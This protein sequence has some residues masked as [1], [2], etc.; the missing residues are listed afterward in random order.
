MAPYYTVPPLPKSSEEPDA[1]ED[2][3]V[4][5]LKHHP[6]IFWE[7]WP[8]ALAQALLALVFL[9]KST[10]ATLHNLYELKTYSVS[11]SYI[12]NQEMLE[13]KKKFKKE[14]ILKCKYTWRFAG[15]KMGSPWMYFV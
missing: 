2:F 4:G 11:T 7:M 15:I 3:S 10:D 1:V 13:L 6:A 9:V 8:D 14:I 12:I 5:F